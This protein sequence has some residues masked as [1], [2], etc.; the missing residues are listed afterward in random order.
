MLAGLAHGGAT[1]PDSTRAV[2]NGVGGAAG[3]VALSV[4]CGLEHGC[5]V[6]RVG[7]HDRLELPHPQ[8]RVGGARPGLR[9]GVLQR[10]DDGIALLADGD[11]V[12]E[13]VAS[14]LGHLPRRI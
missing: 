1:V 8:P 5:E 11:D 14:V 7:G 6:G 9:V 10:R 4:P 12:A 2:S 3:G 13:Q